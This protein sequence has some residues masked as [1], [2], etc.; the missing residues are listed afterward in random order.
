[1]NRMR[2]EFWTLL[3]GVDEYQP[4]FMKA[5]HLHD[6]G[7]VQDRKY[8]LFAQKEEEDEPQVKP[9]NNVTQ[10]AK[11]VAKQKVRPRKQSRKKKA[12]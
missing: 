9:K 10:F 1:M 4:L 8:E 12:A 6:P 2:K 3:D 7:T 11:K 5:M